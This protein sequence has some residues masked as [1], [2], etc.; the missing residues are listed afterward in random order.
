MIKRTLYFGNPARLRLEE[1]QLRIQKEN[2]EV[3]KQ[4]VEDLGIVI[5]D[6]PQITVSQGLIQCLM[7]NGCAVLWCN[8][9]HMP[10]GLLLPFTDNTTHSAVLK[11]QI[12]C[13]LPLAKQ[14][15]KQIVIQ[16]IRNQAALLK[17]FELPYETV[18]AMAAEI[19]SGDDGNTEGRAAAVYWKHLFEHNRQFY[20]HRYGPSPNHLLN[21]AYSVLRAVAGRSLVGS[22]LMPSVGIHHRN[23]YNP[24][25]LADDVMEPYRPY[26]DLL[27]LECVEQWG[28]ELPDELVPEIKKVLL[29]LPAMDVLQNGDKSPLM[30]AMQRTTASLAACLKGDKKK[31]I[32]PDF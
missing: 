15:W 27:V 22:G 13:T 28:D 25:C 23:K 26:A 1:A 29:T 21:Y 17:M 24:Y 8:S 10:E 30:V 11:A 20:R 6:H 3:V 16:K 19:R 7:E 12:E 9:R 32:L 31:L 5:M 18:G 2:G 4:P 14:L